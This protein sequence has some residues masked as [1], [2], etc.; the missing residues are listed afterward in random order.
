MKKLLLTFGF[1]GLLVSC[2]TTT[3]AVTGRKAVNTVSNETIFPQS[4]TQ[5][6]DVLKSGKVVTGTADAKMVQT[7][8]ERIKN[9]AEQ[10]YAQKGL[11]DQLKGYQWEYKLLDAN[12]VNAWCMPGGKVAVYTGI[13][14]ITQSANG[15]AVVMGHEIGHAL[16]NHSAEQMTRQQNMQLIGS[17]IGSAAGDSSWGATF[18]EFYPVVGQVGLLKYSRNMELDA[19]LTG[20][21]LMA[22][23]GYDPREAI[24]FW[25]RMSKA[26]SGGQVE[27]LST[28]PSDD[29]RI[30][31][32]KEAL[33]TAMAYYNASPY[34]GK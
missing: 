3:N 11:S 23:A 12:Q 10:Y 2:T 9:A 21:Y 6:N 7:V 20:L 31:K 26:G 29:T 19:D 16:A 4:F 32:I 17:L 8:G 27:F 5:Y 25:E 28:H 14:P 13:L 1:V 22:M 33:P 34:K 24:P 15:L 30:A 18:Q